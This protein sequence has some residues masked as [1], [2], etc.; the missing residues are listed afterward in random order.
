MNNR[1]RKQRLVLLAVLLLVL[2]I[3]PVMDAASKPR[4][5]MGI[6]LLY[7]YVF[8]VWAAGIFLLFRLSGGKKNRPNE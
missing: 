5:V 3:Y 8:V 2:L 1:V 6:P 7:L 4:M